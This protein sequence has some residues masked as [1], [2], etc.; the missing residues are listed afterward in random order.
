VAASI[1]ALVALDPNADREV[2]QQVFPQEPAVEVVG[3]VAT[4][5]TPSSG[6]SGAANLLV[7]ACGG[8]S[9]H[10]LGYIESAVK[11]TPDRPVV[12]VCSGHANGFVRRVFE[13][14][15]DDI[16]VVAENGGQ[17]DRTV[18]D[19]LFTFQKAVA[20]RSGARTAAAATKGRMICVLGPKGGI[21]KTLTTAN[22]AISLAQ[23]GHR[24]VVVDLDLQ[25]GDIGLAL[26]LQPA[27]TIYDLAT[28]GGAMDAEK[29]EA[30]LAEHESGA[31]V[32][33][34]PV[35]PDQAGAVTVEFLREL[36]N[37]LRYTNDY[38]VVDTPPGFTPE[39]IASIDSSTHVCMVGM[40]DSLSLKN[41]KLGLETLELMGYESERI[42]V[43]LNRADSNVG[44]TRE[45]VR[46]VVGRE[47]DVL[48][49]SHR[50]IA[51]SANTGAPVVVA[52]K[53]SEAAKAFRRLAETY[54][55]NGNGHPKTPAAVTK[56]DAK[57]RDN[58]KAKSTR[59]PLF[60]KRRKG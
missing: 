42:H 14:G 19:V 60:L 26:G 16:V 7:V 39:V 27:K 24:V 51:R 3:L 37:A 1:R 48:V 53:R 21:G 41:T 49:P 36:Y 40:L 46:A 54:V 8:Y 28:S 44:I 11:E 9:D 58:G 22:L 15:A 35:R 12:V 13:A 32:L 4:D 18:E 25:F 5:G 33:L 6:D 29:V 17:P 38:V 43:V 45:D 34:A 56:A 23:E 30:Y 2:L 31:R 20:R 59:K 50:D 55:G 52:E 47:P 10:A 57:S